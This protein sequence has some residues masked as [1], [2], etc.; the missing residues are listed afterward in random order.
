MK[1]TNFRTRGC[2]VSLLIQ[3]I[4]SHISTNENQKNVEEERT[5][6][7][8]FHLKANREWF[9]SIATNCWRGTNLKKSSGWK[10]NSQEWWKSK[11]NRE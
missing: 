3:Y 2:F 6:S 1:S 5:K 11:R 8:K 4:V 10:K 9:F 7:R